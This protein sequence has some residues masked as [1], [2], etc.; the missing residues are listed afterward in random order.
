V[1]TTLRAGAFHRV[2]GVGAIGGE[3]FFGD[4]HVKWVL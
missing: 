3:L 2:S 4:A 1:E